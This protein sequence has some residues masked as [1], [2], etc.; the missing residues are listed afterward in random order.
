MLDELWSPFSSEYDFN[1]ASWFVQSNVAK[2]QI[3]NYLG[4]GLGGMERG[5]FRSAY[6]LE[7]QLETL[8]L[9][10]EYLS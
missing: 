2:M 10:R 6:T 8:D 3:D 7:T 1:L 4:K 5:S 9:F